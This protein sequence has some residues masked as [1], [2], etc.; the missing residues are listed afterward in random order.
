MEPTTRDKK[1]SFPLSLTEA[2]KRHVENRIAA[3]GFKDR[4]EYFLALMM[5]EEA[6]ALE[7]V[8][9][10]AA[11]QPVLKLSATGMWDIVKHLEE[12]GLVKT[13]VSS[14]VEIAVA[15]AQA[16]YNLPHKSPAAKAP[17]KGDRHGA[18]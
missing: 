11:R 2:E 17:R 3:H 6:L 8:H 4:N 16:P 7:A 15:E 10:V 12:L 1:S 13:S 9:D 5:M 14:P 18:A